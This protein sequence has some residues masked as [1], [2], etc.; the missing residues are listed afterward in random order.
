MLLCG[1]PQ[2][3]HASLARIRIELPMTT[4]YDEVLA[5]HRL[6]IHSKTALPLINRIIKWAEKNMKIFM[7]S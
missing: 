7:V 4:H 1:T 6:R 3:P 2:K 5:K